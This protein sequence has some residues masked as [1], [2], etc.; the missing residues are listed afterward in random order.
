MPPHTVN[1][2]RYAVA[3]GSTTYGLGTTKEQKE[4]GPGWNVFRVRRD[5]KACTITGVLVAKLMSCVPLFALR[6]P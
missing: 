5:D 2:C 1:I 6:N 4:D 3:N